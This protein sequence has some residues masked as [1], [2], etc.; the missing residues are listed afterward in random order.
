MTADPLILDF[1]IMDDTHREAYELLE[2]IN[3]AADEELPVL[4][5][6]LIDH[7]KNHF[8][9]ERQMMVDSRFGAQAEHEGEHNR[10]LGS[11][12][13]FQAALTRGRVAF[14]KAFFKETLP[15]MLETHIRSVDSALAAH[16]KKQT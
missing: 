2:K 4:V 3:Q 5:S 13:Q 8:E 11:L 1:D 15:E 12:V 7:T 14:V 6:L 10:L 9:Q 16:M